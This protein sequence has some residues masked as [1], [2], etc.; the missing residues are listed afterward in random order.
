MQ[1]VIENTAM[2]E[3]AMQ[4][5]LN[6]C[7]CLRFEE[8]ATHYRVF[9]PEDMYPNGVQCSKGMGKRAALQKMLEVMER[10]WQSNGI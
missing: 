8:D 6:H 2:V 10:H 4:N 3:Q 1:N 9:Y 7:M 5:I